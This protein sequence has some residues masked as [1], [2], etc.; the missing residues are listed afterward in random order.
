MKTLWPNFTH[1][2]KLIFK[3]SP[4]FTGHVEREKPS[5]L[6]QPD[7][8]QGEKLLPTQRTRSVTPDLK[9]WYNIFHIRKS[10]IKFVTKLRTQVVSLKKPAN[11]TNKCG[12][13]FSQCLVCSKSDARG[14]L[15]LFLQIQLSGTC[16]VELFQALPW[17]LLEKGRICFR[18]IVEFV[19]DKS[20]LWHYITALP[21]RE[22][23]WGHVMCLGEPLANWGNG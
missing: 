9:F 23:G 3:P 16:R 1:K 8:S 11:K 20:I 14:L 7:Q 18:I 5:V 21:W 6:R 12:N 19:E 15:L 22:Y 10:N 13:R 4:L 2:Y 17:H